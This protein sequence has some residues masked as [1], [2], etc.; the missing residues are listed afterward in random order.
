MNI[1]DN[2]VR[3]AD[4]VYTDR[5]QE[6][7]RSEYEKQIDEAIEIS[8]Q[9]LQQQQQMYALYEKQLIEDYAKETER[10]SNMFKDLLFQLQ[11]TAAFDKSTAEAL[12][13]LTPIIETYCAQTMEV[14]ELD[15]TAYNKVF[16]TLKKNRN[17][18]AVS[19]VLQSIVNKL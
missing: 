7:T 12:D 9:E 3:E 13:I 8:L 11:R 16:G 17:A 1:D 10:R 6:D 18:S 2:D 19:E 15:E 14:F 4:E 5:L